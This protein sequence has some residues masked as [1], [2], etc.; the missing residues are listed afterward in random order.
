MLAVAAFLLAGNALVWN[1]A[2]SESGDGTL[3]VSFL[4]VGQGDAVFVRGPTGAQLLIDGGPDSSVLR[5]LGERMPFY[6]RSIDVV[7]ATHPDGDHIG[8]LPR[9]LSR[10]RAG[11]LLESGASSDGGGDEALRAAAEASGTRVVRAER[12][13][14]VDLGGGAKLSILFPDRDM[15][16][17][18]TNQS[19]VVA[20]LEYGSTS[21]LFTG[22]SP[23]SVESYLS[24]L[25][26][27]GLDS[28]VLKVA[29]HGSDTST[30]PRFVALV[31]PE[32]AVISAGKGNKFG[33]P[34]ESVVGALAAAGS[35]VVGTYDDGTVTFVSDGT[36]VVR[37]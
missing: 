30:S 27:S 24:S 26:G 17:S 37:R 2:F 5:E 34:M 13:H 16:G 8:G 31:S 25:E 28:D 29:H 15:S 21:F 14:V 9:V 36:R 32:Y 1:A 22:D 35:S 7:V 12:G 6:D 18:D 3:A 11:V 10:Y 23:A 20:K 33:H 4:D 19:S